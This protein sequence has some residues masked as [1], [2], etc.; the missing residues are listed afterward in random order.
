MRI[1]LIL[2]I[3]V[4]FQGVLSVPLL[5]SA[6]LVAS[7]LLPERGLGLLGGVDGIDDDPTD[8]EAPEATAKSVHAKSTSTAEDEFGGLLT[9][10]MSKTSSRSAPTSTSSAS[11]LPTTYSI[12]GTP[13]AHAATAVQ[14]SSASS[15]TIT[16]PAPTVAVGVTKQAP[17]TPPAEALEWKIIGVA[18]IAIS[19]VAASILAVVF[20]DSWS[21]FLCDLIR[22][23]KRHGGAEN[24]VPDWEKRSW[25][26]KLANE[27]GHRYP[28]LSSLESITK[29]Q[30]KDKDKDV[31]T[32]TGRSNQSPTLAYLSPASPEVAYPYDREV[33]HFTR[34]A[35]IRTPAT[36]KGLRN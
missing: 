17:S 26:F 3:I 9:G 20:F 13:G 16:S 1:H 4:L 19:F 34:Q 6:R 10:L 35:S 29:M 33:D 7:T 23:K 28:S 32:M 15:S 36:V 18:V 24:L 25:E 21:R 11:P 31:G 27:E 30:E 8:E 12:I 5:P 2:G 22:G 14:T